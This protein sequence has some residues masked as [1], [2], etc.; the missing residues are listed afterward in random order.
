MNGPY[1]SKTKIMYKCDKCDMFKTTK[2]IFEHGMFWYCF[3]CLYRAPT[4]QSMA[5]FLDEHYAVWR[6]DDVDISV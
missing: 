4:G 3:N 6:M 5:T 2:A 1:F